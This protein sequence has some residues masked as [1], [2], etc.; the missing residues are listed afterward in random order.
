[1]T[2]YLRSVLFSNSMSFVDVM[3]LFSLA[4]RFSFWIGLPLYVLW[5]V[6]IRPLVAHLVGATPK[7]LERIANKK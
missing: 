5:L 4:I 1:M 7:D 2:N 3:V 6:V